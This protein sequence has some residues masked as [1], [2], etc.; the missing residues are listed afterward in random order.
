MQTEFETLCQLLREE[1]FQEL[2]QYNEQVFKKKYGSTAI[3]EILAYENNK[4]AVEYILS[5]CDMISLAAQG[6]ARGLHKEFVNDLFNR[7]ANI[8]LI[9]QG[10]ALGGHIDYVD[11]LLKRGADIGYAASGAGFGGHRDPATGSVIAEGWS[12]AGLPVETGSSDEAG[13][14]ALRGKMTE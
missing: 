5:K 13:Y 8:D 9:V 4:V 11:A 7:G 6:A 1:N 3:I 12:Q 14:E 2:D 10:A